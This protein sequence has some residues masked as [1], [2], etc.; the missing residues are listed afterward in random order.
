MAVLIEA[1]VT[2]VKTF[3][4][5]KKIKWQMIAAAVLSVGVCL[6]YSLDIPALVGIEG[7]VPYVGNVITGIL[8]SRG[9]NYIY[10]L[11]GLLKGKKS[12]VYI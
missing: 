6:A 7:S 1:I 10:D 5:D 2:Y 8:I 12:E 4:I 3:A 9:S 11:L